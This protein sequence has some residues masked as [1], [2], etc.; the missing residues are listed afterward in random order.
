MRAVLE[1]F[2]RNHTQV[3]LEVDLRDFKHGLVVVKS[4]YVQGASDLELRGQVT[5]QV[6]SQILVWGGL[7]ACVGILVV[8]PADF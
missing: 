2:I 3:D 5:D 1:I 4:E 7:F 6:E 8:L